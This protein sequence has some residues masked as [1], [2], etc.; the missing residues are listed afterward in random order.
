MN[1]CPNCNQPAGVIRSVVVGNAIVRGC[2]SC[3]SKRVQPTELAAKNRRSADYRDH[4][5][6]LVQPFQSDFINIYSE[7]KA[8]SFGWTDAGIRKHGH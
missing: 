2:E 5:E 8:R 6:D 7:E 3:L 4:A 1:K